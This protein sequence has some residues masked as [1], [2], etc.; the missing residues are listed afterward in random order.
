MP[1][2]HAQ[3]RAKLLWEAACER[4]RN[5]LEAPEGAREGTATERGQALRLAQQ[6]LDAVQEAFEME[7][8]DHPPLASSQREHG[9]SDGNE[10]EAR[11]A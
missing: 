5:S 1:K 2:T 4:L 8:T 6:A 9:P 11:T 7:A 10:T 3:L